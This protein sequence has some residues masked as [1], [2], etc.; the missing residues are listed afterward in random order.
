MLSCLGRF[1][2][3]PEFP[4]V[5][6]SPAAPRIPCPHCQSSIKSAGL[7]PGSECICPRC[8]KSFVVPSAEQPTPAVEAP[9]VQKSAAVVASPPVVVPPVTNTAPS[10]AET[11]L[12]FG[13]PAKKLDEDIS[14]LCKL[15]G[16]RLYAKPGQ[17]GQSKACPDCFTVNV[18]PAA[19]I[20]P[21][22][23]SAGGMVVTSS[24]NNSLTGNKAVAPAAALAAAAAP[25]SVQAE[26][27][28]EFKLSEP[29]DLT[30][31]HA[32]HAP[33][34]MPTPEEAKEH[35]DR[36]RWDDSEYGMFTLTGAEDDWKQ[37]PFILNI[38]DILA[39]NAV[40]IRSFF[41]FLAFVGIGF[42]L[43]KLHNVESG[44]TRFVMQIILAISTPFMAALAVSWLSSFLMVV[45]QTAN[46]IVKV[47]LS[48]TFEDYS[49]IGIGLR[50][51][52]AM[53]L[54]LIP[55]LIVTAIAFEFTVLSLLYP[56]ISFAT[57]FPIL[58]GSLL[59][60][61]SWTRFVSPA[62]TSTL[63]TH[64]EKWFVFHLISSVVLATM[65]AGLAM[66]FSAD[67]PYVIAGTLLYMAS[68]W[69]YGRM[70][71]RL[72]WVL[73]RQPKGYHPA[74]KKEDASSSSK[75][76]PGSLQRVSSSL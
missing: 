57:L 41:Y 66:F 16:S 29:V 63:K 9:P 25:A 2:V 32:T 65:F 45:S 22:S 33:L 61:E 49:W 40:L 28:D 72:F 24:I 70:L 51:M 30:H 67:A 58:M 54:S 19:P 55:G 8:S 75:H 35:V 60:E 10:A 4:V 48:E 73:D 31:M 47:E 50:G 37:S 44:N 46:G 7:A 36:G 21:T 6:A 53:V 59:W 23:P 18:V 15:C 68:F 39:N 13:P 34:R 26:E 69:I 20:K 76:P 11:P 14:F 43:T 27:E 56:M 38:V 1:H 52:L 42:Y 17:V 12:P 3:S 5:T 62:L 71:G 64:T 74:K